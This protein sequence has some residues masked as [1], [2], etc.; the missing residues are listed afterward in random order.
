MVFL[1]FF[2]QPGSG[3]SQPSVADLHAEKC[4]LIR[5]QL[6]LLLH[7]SICQHQEQQA[8]SGAVEPCN[9]PHCQTTQNV[10]TH[11][12]T[13]TAGRTCQGLG[14]DIFKNNFCTSF[15]DESLALMLTVRA[16]N[17]NAILKIHLVFFCQLRVGL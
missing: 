4:G 3:L 1:S 17:F 8:Q 15:L 13:C 7:A 14:E 2:L 16:L 10:L 12:T 5:Q 9:L 6:A 11:M